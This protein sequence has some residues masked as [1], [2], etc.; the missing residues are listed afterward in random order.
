MTRSGKVLI[1][2]VVGL[3]GLAGCGGTPSVDAPRVVEAHPYKVDSGVDSALGFFMN[4]HVFQGTVVA[5]GADVL[6]RDVL[7][8]GT[9][10]EAVYTPVT[11]RITEVYRG[12]LKVNGDVVIRAM[13]GQAEGLVYRIEEAPA[14]STFTLG[15]TLVVFGG[16][17]STVDSES[18]AAITPN[19]VYRLAGR[20]YVDATYASGGVNGTAPSRV[21]A[22]SLR[23]RLLGLR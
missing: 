14:K 4:R 11:I 21:S 19:F 3:A 10:F 17:L 20:E 22:D 18:L 12:D 7:D 6:A 15:A 2:L 5:V 9:T 13:G 23:G 16:E 8:S 1:A